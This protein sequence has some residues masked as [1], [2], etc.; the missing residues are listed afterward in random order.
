[1]IACLSSHCVVTVPSEKQRPKEPW[2]RRVLLASAG[3][4]TWASGFVLQENLC[5]EIQE[6]WLWF[7]CG[8]PMDPIIISEFPNISTFS[9]GIALC[10][11]D[12]IC[13]VPTCIIRLFLLLGA[14][15]KQ[16]HFLN[17]FAKINP[18][19]KAGWINCA[20]CL[21]C[22]ARDVKILWG[23]IWKLQVVIRSCA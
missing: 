23:T 19:L 11:F 14:F 12:G 9:L 3:W 6:W 22:M 15:W 1:M 16:F 13:F 17:L 8:F 2:V 21:W 7:A 5:Q 20:V 4:N 18:H 10:L